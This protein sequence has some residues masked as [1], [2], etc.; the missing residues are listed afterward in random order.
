LLIVFLRSGS[1]FQLFLRKRDAM[2]YD[3]THLRL[4]AFINSLIILA[5]KWLPL[6][7]SIFSSSP[8]QGIMSSKSTL[9][10]PFAVALGRGI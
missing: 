6:S 3:G 2:R 4:S 9:T 5:V 1:S 10:T 7:E 8:N